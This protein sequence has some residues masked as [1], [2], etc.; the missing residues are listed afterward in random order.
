MSAPVPPSVLDRLWTSFRALVGIEIAPLRFL[1]TYGYTITDTDGTTV[2][3]TPNDPSQNLPDGKGWLMRSCV[4]GGTATP[5]VGNKCLVTFEN[6]DPSIPICVGCDGPASKVSLDATSELDL[7]ASSGTVAIAGGGSDAARVADTALCYFPPACPI[8][9][10]INGTMPFVG[11][12]TIPGPG[13]ASIQTGSS[14][15]QIGG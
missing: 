11:V 6:G 3:A 2:D 9:G 15:C 12:M 5:T 13:I 4:C 10:V 8:A 14:I 7:G 1:G